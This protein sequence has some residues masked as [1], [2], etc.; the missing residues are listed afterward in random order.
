[1]NCPKCREK[2]I[3]YVDWSK[4]MRWYKTEC[5]SCAVQ[6]RANIA[7]RIGFVLSV[8]AGI[9]AALLFEIVTSPPSILAPLGIGLLVMFVGATVTWFCGGYVQP[10]ELSGRGDR[11]SV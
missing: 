9:L 4:G 3:G 6:L 11:W 5:N 8:G 10:A 1:M 2:A 7:T